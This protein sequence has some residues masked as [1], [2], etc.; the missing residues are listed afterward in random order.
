MVCFLTQRPRFFD[1]HTRQKKVVQHGGTQLPELNEEE[2]ELPH[3]HDLFNIDD[4]HIKII[5]RSHASSLPPT[6]DIGDTSSDYHMFD[7]DIDSSTDDPPRVVASRKRERVLLDES[8][9]EAVKPKKPM[10]KAKVCSIQI[11]PI[12]L[13]TLFSR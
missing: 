9:S 10:K 3:A 11:Y 1:S 5:S 7:V 6:S 12:V 8:F 2:S 4:R 13:T